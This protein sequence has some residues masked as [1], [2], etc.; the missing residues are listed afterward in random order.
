MVWLYK[1]SPFEI[2][3]IAA[4]LVLYLAYIIRVVNTAKHLGSRFSNVF[5][6]LFLRS[7]YFGLII[8]A[9]LGPSFGESKQEIQ[10]KGKDIFLCVDL[11][12]SMNAGD[13]QPTRLEKMKFELKK[14]TKA[15]SSDRLGLI[16]FSSEAFVQS[17]L[18]F[19]QN[20]LQLFIETLNTGLV[21]NAGTDFAPP[22]KIALEKL[23]EDESQVTQQKSKVIVLISDG[24]DFGKEASD[25]SQ[26]INGSG[27]KLFTLGVG[28]ARGSKIMTRR[29]F[30]K[31]R[32]G[33]DV[34]TKLDSKSL[35]RLA[36][37]TDGKYFE[38]NETQNDVARLIN[39]INK[40]EGEVR[41]SRQIDV[42]ANRYYYFLGLALLLILIDVITSVKTVKI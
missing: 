5:I 25:V 15:F 32:E 42:S 38:I 28:T 3:L 8:V 39:T 10:S 13:V 30:K 17:P 34:I 29:G 33:N 21:P 7:A 9:V 40:I 16:I 6:K 18:T 11:S 22:L 19:D 4:F 1:L 12:Q 37:D 23:N 36:S 35:R 20:A 2:I 14:I 24:E 41:D 31:D 27:I 26:D